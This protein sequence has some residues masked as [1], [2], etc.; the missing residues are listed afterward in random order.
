MRFLEDGKVEAIPLSTLFCYA[1]NADTVRNRG[2]TARF[3]IE[4]KHFGA[5]RGSQGTSHSRTDNERR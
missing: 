5:E 2:L 3:P 1:P 4:H